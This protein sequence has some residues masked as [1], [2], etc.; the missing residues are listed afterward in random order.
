MIDVPRRIRAG[1]M[2]QDHF[3]VEYCVDTAAY[4][5]GGFWLLRPYRLEPQKPPECAQ[6]HDWRKAADSNHRL[7]RAGR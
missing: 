6:S 5:T 7:D 3:G 4:A 1:A 2:A